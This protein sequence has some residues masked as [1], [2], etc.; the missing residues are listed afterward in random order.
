MPAAAA[1]TRGTS[2]FGIADG[3]NS[4]DVDKMSTPHAP[5][6]TP[7]PAISPSHPGPA[8]AVAAVAGQGQWRRLRPFDLH[9]FVHKYVKERILAHALDGCHEQLRGDPGACP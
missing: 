1:A 8:V 6:D 4:L 2:A 9:T 3:S 7:L 5:R